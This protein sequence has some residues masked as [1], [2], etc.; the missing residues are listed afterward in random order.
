MDI[1]G[2]PLPQTL[3]K[4]VS[5]YSSSNKLWFANNYIYFIILESNV[6]FVFNSF[7]FRIVFHAYQEVDL[8]MGKENRVKVVLEVKKEFNC[9]KSKSSQSITTVRRKRKI[10]MRILKMKKRSNQK[11]K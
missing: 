10:P 2:N 3:Q 8:I 11:R 5:T 6:I 9:L 7:L 1:E 4:Q